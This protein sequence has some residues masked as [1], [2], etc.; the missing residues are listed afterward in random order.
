MMEVRLQLLVTSTRDIRMSAIATLTWNVLDPH[1]S[2]HPEDLPW[3]VEEMIFTNSK[4]GLV[5]LSPQETI[6]RLQERISELEE[7]HDN[8]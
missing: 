4:G 5:R 6:E 2:V 3:T 8:G 7:D 1:D